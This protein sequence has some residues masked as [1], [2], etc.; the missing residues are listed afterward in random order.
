[1]EDVLRDLLYGL[2]QRVNVSS[3][4]G[5]SMKKQNTLIYKWYMDY[6]LT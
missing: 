5:P 6:Q 1:M 2:E 3:Q 4:P